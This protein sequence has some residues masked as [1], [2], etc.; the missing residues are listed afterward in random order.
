MKRPAERVSIEEFQD[1]RRRLLDRIG[2]GAVALVQGGPKGR[3]HD[4]FR[5]TNDFYY[6]CGVETP[7]AY[8]MLDGR[9]GKTTLFLPYQSEERAARD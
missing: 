4:K 5:Q 3:T 2:S 9:S 8:L 7:H 6:L 1:R